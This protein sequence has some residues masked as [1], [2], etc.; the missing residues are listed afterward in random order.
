M[1]DPFPD[2]RQDR[3]AEILGGWTQPYLSQL[4]HKS[5]ITAKN[6]HFAFINDPD[7]AVF[8]YIIPLQ[9]VCARLPPVKGIDPAIPKDPQFHQKMKSKQLN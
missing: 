5:K 4:V 9:M 6:M 3:L 1:L 8:E 2:E 7:F